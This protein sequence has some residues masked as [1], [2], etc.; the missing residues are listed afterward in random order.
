[1][2]THPD[3]HP[4][5]L[6]AAQVRA[7][8]Q[9]YGYNELPTQRREGML[10]ILWNVMSSP[11]IVLLLVAGALY[12]FLGEKM[13]AGVLL[14]F[15]FVV[16][17]ITFYQQRKTTRALDALKVLA[18]GTARVMRDGAEVRVP[19]REIVPGDIVKIAEGDRVPA[20]GVVVAMM[21]LM[22]EE[23]ILTGE[24]L[25]V[26]KRVG[27]D[28]EVC[29]TPGGDDR[30][31]VFSGTMVTQGHATIRVTATGAQTQIGTIGTSLAAIR[32][33]RPLLTKEVARL[34]RVVAVMS[35]VLCGAVVVVYG[36]FWGDWMQGVLSGLSL[37]M[38]L[39]PEEFSVVLTVFLAIGAWR[40]STKNVLLRNTAAIETLGAAN[41]LCVDKTGTLTKNVMRLRAIVYD[42]AMRMCDAASPLE[43]EGQR[44]IEIATLASQESPFDPLER[45]IVDA[46]AS[47][48][49]CAAFV[50]A[51]KTMMREYPLSDA[52]LAVAR[53][54][55]RE[56]D[57]QCTIAVKGA[58]EAIVD[59]CH[60]DDTAAAALNKNLEQLSRRGWRVLG[61]AAA[62]AS[63]ADVQHTDNVHDYH[64][65]F[66]GLLAFADPVRDD[67]PEAVAECMRA[68]VDVV[69]ITGDYAGTAQ[70]I[71]REAGLRD[72]QAIMTGE[73]V[74]ACSP[75]QLRERVRGVSVFARVAPQQ[76]LAIVD[77]LKANGAVVAMTGD[78]VNDAPA[79]TASH[80]GIA[81]G[82]R[83]TDV[84]R[85]AADIV[86]LDDRFTSIVAGVRMGRRIYDNIKKAVSYIIAV[87]VP[88]AGM[89]FV[90]MVLHVPAMLLPVHI[91]FLELIIDPACSLVFESQRAE[92]NSM[93]RPPRSLRQSLLGR[94]LFARSITEGVGVLVAVLAVYA[95][96]F[97]GGMDEDT[98]RGV[99]LIAL[100]VGNVALIL[101]NVSAHG[102]ATVSGNRV[103][104]WVV[105]GALVALGLIFAV[106]LLRTLFHVAVPP[107]LYGI[108]A[109]IVP[110]VVVAVYG[111]VH[112]MR[113][114]V[115]H[116]VRV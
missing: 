103:L 74:A 107:L 83:G 10:R 14:L 16:I 111:S 95:W 87:H 27:R 12:L 30:G 106:P 29:D 75:Q 81:M 19:V 36:V 28:N 38:A 100:V 20:D 105:G 92:K 23:S 101:V 61:V 109:V 46:V 2:Y 34:V 57:D 50:Q 56:G 9:T 77:A 52:M 84:A 82:E 35:V 6:T 73:D 72:P 115:W 64:F 26:R 1:M 18:S 5:G 90:P 91:A 98:V 116:R 110:S 40:M 97:F 15:V 48:A 62:R 58:P 99:T 65:V 44:L 104:W 94:R 80:V 51:R 108:G 17:G 55:E 71:A 32:Q 113:A 42:G 67:V 68:G 8:R 43:A 112:R 33:E 7:A 59:L 11:M 79:L 25:A 41:V 86:L 96:A 37:S 69:M 78:G 4:R 102:T 66:A 39:L 70:T 49:E 53:A 114:I 89:A 63:R 93:R 3:H 47:R 45:G 21:S 54:W 85:E 60:M 22:V 88:I 24:S 31:C 13:D 76:K